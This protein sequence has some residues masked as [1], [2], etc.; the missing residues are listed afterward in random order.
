MNCA[1]YLL[2]LGVFGLVVI[3]VLQVCNVLTARAYIN[4]RLRALASTLY[5]PLD[6]PA[7]SAL[8]STKRFFLG[9][10]IAL[11]VVGVGYLVRSFQ[12]PPQLNVN[13]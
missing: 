9:A 11:A 4:A 10:Q 3:A 1:D 8:T 5:A 12:G 6:V 2:T 7:P 13:A